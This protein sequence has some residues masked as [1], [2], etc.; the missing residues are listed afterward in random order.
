[1]GLVGF[2][3]ALDRFNGVQLVVGLLVGEGRL[4]L[5]LPRAVRAV[6]MPCDHFA[7]GIELEQ[8]VGDLGDRALGALLDNCQSAVPSRLMLA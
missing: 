5:L 4:H 2:H 3:V 8:V 7:L 1:M 6:G